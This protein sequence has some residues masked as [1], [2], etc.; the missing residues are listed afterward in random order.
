MH[1]LGESH[2]FL[3]HTN[4]YSV[5]PKRLAVQLHRRLNTTNNANIDQI[6]K[7][8][9]QRD[10]MLYSNTKFMYQFTL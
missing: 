6:R 1:V 5:S 7:F 8:V 3:H 4:M 9:M 2:R 10:R